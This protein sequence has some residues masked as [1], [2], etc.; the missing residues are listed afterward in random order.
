MV[1]MKGIVLALLLVLA[2]SLSGCT[3][4]STDIVVSGSTTV[5]PIAEVAGEDY[6]KAHP[7]VSVLVSGLGS[8]AGIEAVGITKTAD[9]GTS[10]RKLKDDELKLGLTVI[11]IAHDG[12]AVVVNPDNPVRDL[13]LD[14]LRDIFA[15]KITNWKEVG[16]ADL[17]ITLVNR[18][19]SSGTRDAFTKIVMDKTEF[20][21]NAVV[22]PGTGQVREVISR[23]KG[24]IGYISEG[25]VNKQ[26]RALSVNGI[27]PT[28]VNIASEKY[29]LS[30]SLYFLARKDISPEA[31]GYIDYVLSDTIQQGPVRDAGYLPVTGGEK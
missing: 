28:P 11:P 15:G 24:A 1:K 4:G 3:K 30:R 2:L 27:A 18:D 16:G 23:T 10:S 26:V 22:L 21:L 12:I 25:F 31:Q 9:I 17:P 6:H 14:D 8:S 7:E 5:E 20:N 13:K 19:E 29:P